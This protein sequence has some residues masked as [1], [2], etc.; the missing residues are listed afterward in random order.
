MCP[1]LLMLLQL[2]A[3][4]HPHPSRHVDACMPVV[5]LASPYVT[6]EWLPRQRQLHNICI[7]FMPTWRALCLRLVRPSVRCPFTPISYDV[8][9]QWKNLNETW[10]KYYINHAGG[11]RWKGFQDQRSI[12]NSIIIYL[13]R[14]EGSTGKHK[15]TNIQ[16]IQKTRDE[17][18]RNKTTMK[19]QI[20]SHRSGKRMWHCTFYTVSWCSR[21]DT[22]FTALK[23][24]IRGYSRQTH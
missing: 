11:H 9:S 1:L 3:Y 21:P 24:E 23:H 2:L 5:L 18:I 13:L 8:I 10:H 7:V 19:L 20:C 14:H 6:C 17:A 22:I 15:H 4:P 16:N 12:N